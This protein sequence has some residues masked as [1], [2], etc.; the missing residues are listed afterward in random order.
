VRATLLSALILLVLP[1]AEPADAAS[2]VA[3]QDQNL[4]QAIQAPVLKW[5]NAGCFSSWCET[6]WY[7]SPAVADLDGDG[8]FEVIASAYS[9]VVLDGETGALEWRMKS[10]HD[11]S[12]PGAD[13]VGRTWPGIVVTDLDGNGDLEIVTAHSGG[14]VSVYDHQGYFEPGWPQA[15]TGNELR[16]LSVYDL[17]DDGSLEVIVTGAVYGQVNTWVYEH[18]GALRPGWPQLSDDSGY[19][20]GIFNDNAAVADLDGDGIGEIVVPSDVHY[21]CAYEPDGSQIPA[22]AMYG[23]KGWGKVGVWES[24]DIEL[25]GWGACNGVREESYR[26]NFAHGPAAIADV[27]GNGAVE[28]VA[29]GNVYD[30][31]VGHPPGKYNGVYLFNADRSRFNSAGYDWR[32]LPVDTG[33]PLSED[34]G[35]IENNQPNPVA[36]DLDGDGELEILYSSYDGR[37]HAFWLDKTEHGNWPYSVYTGGAYRFAS[38]P[39]VADLDA[40]GHAEVLFASWVQKGSHQTGKLHILNYLGYP[41]YGVDLPPAYGSPDWNGAL[42]APTLANLDA[43]A[44]LEVVLNTAHSGFVAYDLPGTASARVLWGTGRG[45]YQRTGSLLHG[46]LQNS[47]KQVQP[48]Q[49]GPGDELT[50]TIRLENPG[51]ALAGVHVTDT[52][53]AE[54]HYLGNVWCSSGN[55]VEAGGVVTWAGDVLAAEPVTIT[56]GVTVS[57]EISMPQAIA[58]TALI[59]DGQGNVWQRQAVVVVNGYAVYLPLVRKR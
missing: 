36:A 57:N 43:D 28:V 49:P 55:C 8:T 9:I 23:G 41:L 50:Y 4:T 45:N 19:A 14:V 13:N 27:N 5:Q 2:P 33:A 7:S 42:P 44:D 15:P 48:T 16:G 46:T 58:N 53:P 37:V 21:I 31:S 40:D 11:R 26:T 35:V 52:L 39:V 20:Y 24:L 34:Y 25:R 18:T 54:L 30:C 56:Y 59:D 1:L 17:D 6:G 32:T 38:E 12:E 3:S 51:P 10:G 29:T 47:S 22:N